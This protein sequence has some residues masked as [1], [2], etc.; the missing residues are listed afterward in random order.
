MC[1]SEDHYEYS[2]LKPLML[3]VSGTLIRRKMIPSGVFSIFDENH[4]I[5]RDYCLTCVMNHGVLM[6]DQL[7][8]VDLGYPPF[9]SDLGDILFVFL[10][11]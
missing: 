10:L 1:V 3:T 4:L 7:P 2:R 6:L 5:E 8:H 11:S 9:E